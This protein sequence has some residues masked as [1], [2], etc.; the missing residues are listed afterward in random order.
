MTQKVIAVDP[1]SPVGQVSGVLQR[2]R[3]IRVPVVSNG[4]LVGIISRG[5]V[6]RAALGPKLSLFD[7]ESNWQV[8]TVYPPEEGVTRG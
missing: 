1:D 2:E 6:L 5:N 4:A 8:S 7:K 3:I